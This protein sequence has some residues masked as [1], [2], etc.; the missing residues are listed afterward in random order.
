MPSGLRFVVALL[1]VVAVATVL[2]SPDPTD[3]VTGVLHQHVK[4]QKLAAVFAVSVGMAVRSFTLLA[5]S[6]KSPEGPLHDI[7]SLFCVRLC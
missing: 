2:I 7:S 6:S 5:L 3:D 4:L 1:I